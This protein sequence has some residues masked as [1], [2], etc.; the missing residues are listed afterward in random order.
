MHTYNFSSSGMG[1][2][3][4]YKYGKPI[5]GKYKP[6]TDIY[7]KF[8]FKQYMADYRVSDDKSI[9]QDKSSTDLK[10][11][12]FKAWKNTSTNPTLKQNVDN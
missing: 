7:L 8:Y 4:I 1:K 2:S 12:L 6:T 9:Y 10:T 5:F 11:F 3:F